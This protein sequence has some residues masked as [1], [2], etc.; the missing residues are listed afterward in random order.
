[1]LSRG[2][3]GCRQRRAP[4]VQH[5]LSAHRLCSLHLG[6]WAEGC[7]HRYPREA[8]GRFLSAGFCSFRST[9][10]CS[11]PNGP[12]LYL[13][14]LRLKDKMIAKRQS[15]TRLS[16][17]A[18]LALTQCPQPPTDVLPSRLQE[19]LRGGSEEGG[20]LTPARTQTPFL[21]LSCASPR[22]LHAVCPPSDGQQ[23]RLGRVPGG[24]HA[25]PSPTA[26]L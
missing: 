7:E 11:P 1:M 14:E 15:Q 5:S 2:Q 18:A 16:D 26:H 3:Q 8:T 25:P 21:S 13:R 19:A 24:S 22:P 20:G 6:A 10:S 4:L 9:I 23:L 12:I 17:T